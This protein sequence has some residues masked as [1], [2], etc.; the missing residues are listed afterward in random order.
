MEKGLLDWFCLMTLE[1]GYLLS[2]GTEHQQVYRAC[3]GSVNI[4][5]RVYSEAAGTNIRRASKLAV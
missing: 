5:A 2:T 4:D 1:N 3:T